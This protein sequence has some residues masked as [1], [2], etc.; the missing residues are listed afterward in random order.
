[1]ELILGHNQFIGISHISDERS[2]E[3]EKKFSDVKNIYKIVETAAKIG[4]HGMIIE[5]HPRMLDFLEYYKQN[6]T[7][8]MEF[9]LQLPYV[10]G[11]I[12]KMNEN[13]LI[14]LVR[15][16]FHRS[17]LKNTSIMAIKNIANL[18]KKDFFSLAISF[19]ELEIMPFI[20]LNIKTVLL[21][22]VFTDIFLS[23]ELS[24]FI[25]TYIDYMKDTIGL[26]P[27]FITLN[28]DLFQRSF[29]QWNIKH[30]LVMT[31]I[32]PGG[33][34][35]NPS[36][37][38]VELA[39]KKYR[40]EIIAMNILGGGAFSVNETYKYF[41]SLEKLNF[42]VVGASSKTHLQELIEV[43]SGGK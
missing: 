19:L 6:K 30:P 22:N 21:H 41:R 9:Y 1:M 33:F 42:C 12:Q 31:P 23:L 5:T 34:D 43:F 29:D 27:G 36:K 7:F 3:R 13:G 4:Y 14:S 38:S 26:N 16:I 40:G 11:Y 24:D 8:D 18:S 32:N 10:Q 17:G 2:R 15:D 37:T 28:F 39:I 25:K 20:D 35:M